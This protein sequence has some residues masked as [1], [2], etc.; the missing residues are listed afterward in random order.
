MGFGG[1][2]ADFAGVARFLTAVF[3]I[4]FLASLIYTTIT[5]RKANPPL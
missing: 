5:G 2:A 3:V 1:L 4:L